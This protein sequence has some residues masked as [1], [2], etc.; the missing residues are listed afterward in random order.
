MKS[1]HADWTLN[2]GEVQNL[3]AFCPAKPRELD[4]EG[5]LLKFNLIFEKY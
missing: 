5:E 1:D 2:I 3:A 4:R